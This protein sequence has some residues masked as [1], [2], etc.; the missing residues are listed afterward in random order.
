MKGGREGGSAP[1]NRR[2][3][4]GCGGG[5]DMFIMAKLVGCYSH[6]RFVPLTP[7][8][9]RRRTKLKTR[10]GTPERAAAGRFRGAER[11][12]GCRGNGGRCRRGARSG[13]KADAGARGARPNGEGGA[14]P[15]RAPRRH[16]P[17]WGRRGTGAHDAPADRGHTQTM[18][19]SIPYKLPRARTIVIMLHRLR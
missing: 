7:N 2:R 3:G 5:K 1:V 11:P 15:A 4:A 18:K 6:P 16:C 9:T 14:R 13:R 12:R 8:G 10:C 17:P 19:P